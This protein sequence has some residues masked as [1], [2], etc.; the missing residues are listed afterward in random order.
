MVCM[1]KMNDL[2]QHCL[3][4]KFTGL[5]CVEHTVKITEMKEEKT[6]GFQ[7]KI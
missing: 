1:K 2:I 3:L 6:I 5:S 4:L 7:T